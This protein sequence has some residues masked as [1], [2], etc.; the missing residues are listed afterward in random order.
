M[1]AEPQPAARQPHKANRRESTADTG[2]TPEWQRTGWDSGFTVAP[3][4]R[5]H[6]IRNGIKQTKYSITFIHLIK[7]PMDI[8]KR[9]S[10]AAGCP[11]LF[12]HSA[13]RVRDG[14]YRCAR[15]GGTIPKPRSASNNARDETVDYNRGRKGGWP[16]SRGSC[17]TGWNEGAPFLA[18]FARSG[19]WLRRLKKRLGV[20]FDVA[21]PMGCRGFSS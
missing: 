11:I 15:G 4:S 12:A 14:D 6:Q 10:Y 3:A 9:S 1:P 16:T 13:K 18:F 20:V 21:T 7:D 5:I 19:A 8:G 2:V 17:R